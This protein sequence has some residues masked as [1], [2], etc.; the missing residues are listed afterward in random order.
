MDYAGFIS[1][2]TPPATPAVT[3]SGG[4]ALTTLS[5]SWSSSDPESPITQYR[6]AIG[7]TPGAHDVVAWTYVSSATTSMTRTGLNLT[8]GLPYYVT[9]GARNEGGLWSDDGV[10]NGVI[11]GVAPSPTPTQTLTPTPDSGPSDTPAQTLTP[12]QRRKYLP[13]IIKGQ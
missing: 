11:A 6:Y 2:K 7:T 5:A 8:Y 3:A 9:V 10:S 12:A 1:N 4:G 13:L